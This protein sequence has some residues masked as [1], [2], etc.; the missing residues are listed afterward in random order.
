MPIA[1]CI[2]FVFF[3]FSSGVRWCCAGVCFTTAIYDGSKTAILA[4]PAAVYIMMIVVT[5]DEDED[6][7][8]DDGENDGDDDDED[9]DDV[10][11]YP[12]FPD[13]LPVVTKNVD[14]VC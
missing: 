14:S 3:L 2:F 8:G 13:A 9:D 6:D 10:L 12:H 7:D 5:I 11:T 4:K 1:C